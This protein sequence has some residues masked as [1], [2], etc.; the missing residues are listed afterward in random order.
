MSKKPKLVKPEEKPVRTL[1]QIQQEYAAICGQLGQL[2]YQ[3]ASSNRSVEQYM[4]K[5]NELNQE[6]GPLVEA[7]RAKQDVK[8]Q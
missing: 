5:L 6:A 2:Y 8:N 3:I 1:Q 4:S 7:E